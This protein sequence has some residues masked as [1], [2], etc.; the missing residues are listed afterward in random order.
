MSIKQLI[1]KEQLKEEN[2]NLL[3][4]IINSTKQTLKYNHILYG[5]VG[6]KSKWL[7][8]EKSFFNSYRDW[9]KIFIDTII[10][11]IGNKRLRVGQWP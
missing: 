1:L 3:R 6:A 9:I 5:R 11:K 4:E 8:Q 7:E 2:S 10:D